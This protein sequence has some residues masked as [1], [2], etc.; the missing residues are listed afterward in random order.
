MILSKITTN[1]IS[2][3]IV[4]KVVYSV[5]NNMLHALPDDLWY[6]TIEHVHDQIAIQINNHI[7]SHLM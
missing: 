4:N 1:R 3:Q 2:N 7:W 6:Y 5:C